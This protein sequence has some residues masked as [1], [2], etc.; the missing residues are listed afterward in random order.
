[1][2]SE[3][4]DSMLDKAKDEELEA[5]LIGSWVI[6]SHRNN[7][8]FRGEQPSYLSLINQV[9]KFMAQQST[10]FQTDSLNIPQKSPSNKSKWRPPPLHTW[11]LNADASWSDSIHRGGVGW[12]IRNWEGDIVL[13]GNRFVE[14]CC[15]VKLLEATAILEGLQCLENHNVLFPL[16]IKTAFVKVGRETNV[17]AHSLARRA[18]G[19]MECEQWVGCIPT[20]LS[21]LANQDLS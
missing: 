3:Y 10:T 13:A 14:A 2:N 16:R 5:L 1:M 19:L 21:T 18:S 8:V 7:V 12:V 6:W 15:N 11:T 4:W 17:C 9:T 20:W